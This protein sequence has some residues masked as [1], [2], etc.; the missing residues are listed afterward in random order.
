[1]RPF[2]MN[3][4]AV[5]SWNPRVGRKGHAVRVVPSPARPPVYRCEA[6]GHPFTVT[7]GTLFADTHLPLRI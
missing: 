5:A 3:R 2:T 7:V 1:M 4:R 6:C